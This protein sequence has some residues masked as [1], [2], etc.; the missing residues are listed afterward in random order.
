VVRRIPPI[1]RGRMGRLPV[2]VPKEDRSEAVVGLPSLA[3][4]KRFPALWPDMARD[5]VCIC[6]L[7]IWE[8]KRRVL[9]GP[10]GRGIA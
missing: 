2:F 7:G 10:L 1:W 3:S 6:Q 9:A 8:T 5:S 4:K